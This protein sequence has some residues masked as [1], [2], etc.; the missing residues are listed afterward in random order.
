[1][2]RSGRDGAWGGGVAPMLVRPYR[3]RSPALLKTRSGAGVVADRRKKKGEL[4]GEGQR[5]VGGV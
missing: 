4:V 1:M 3:E 2:G 5:S